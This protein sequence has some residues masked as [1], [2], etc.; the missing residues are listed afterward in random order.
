MLSYDDILNYDTSPLPEESILAEA[1]R[2]EPQ[3]ALEEV[4]PEVEEDLSLLDTI[5]RGLTHGT[6]GLGEAVGV[7]TQWLGG[8]LGSETIAE[9]GETA[10]KYWGD[11]AEKFGA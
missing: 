11:K 9:A 8:R 2:Y 4:T 3:K 10:S 5:G 1:M 7:G 6:L